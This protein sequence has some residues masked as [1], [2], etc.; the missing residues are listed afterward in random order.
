[1]KTLEELRKVAEDAEIGH[2]ESKDS[3]YFHSFYRQI[4]RG[5]WDAALKALIRCDDPKN[6]EATDIID[7][8]EFRSAW[9]AFVKYLFCWH[10]PKRELPKTDIEVLVMV[11]ADGHTYDV[12]RYDKH[13]WW[14]KAPG[15]GWCAAKYIPIGWRYIHEI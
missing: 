6:C 15:G 7:R 4:F 2:D 13:G 5:G 1:M 11:H 10:D 14:Q 9:G 3:V 8:K 12:M